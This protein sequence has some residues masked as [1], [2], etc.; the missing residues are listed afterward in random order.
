MITLFLSRIGSLSTIAKSA[1]SLW[2]LAIRFS[3][4]SPW[5]IFRPAKF[6]ETFILCSFRQNFRLEK[7]DLLCRRSVA[8]KEGSINKRSSHSSNI[9]TSKLRRCQHRR[10]SH[11][12]DFT[13]PGHLYQRSKI[14]TWMAY[15]QT[16]LRWLFHWGRLRRGAVYAAG[17]AKES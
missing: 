11:Q 13:I 10:R 4:H 6:M 1:R 12:A 7:L 8:T 5:S 2:N 16:A 17:L 3:A 15:L 14:P 9:P